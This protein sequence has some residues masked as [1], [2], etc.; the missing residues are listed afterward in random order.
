MDSDSELKSLC[1]EYMDTKSKSMGLSI[2]TAIILVILNLVF[3]HGFFACRN[4]YRFSSLRT[5]N[6]VL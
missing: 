6:L 1:T 3:K 4:Y 5:V 2:V